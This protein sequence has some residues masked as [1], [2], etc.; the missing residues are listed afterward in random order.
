MRQPSRGDPD[1]R[2]HRWQGAGPRL[3]VISDGPFQ[4]RQLRLTGGAKTIGQSADNDLQLEDEYVSRH[5]ARVEARSDA[6]VIEDT[7]ST[8]GVLVNGRLIRRRM[9]LHPGDVVQLGSLEL[10]LEPPAPGS[11]PT[12]PAPT[13]PQAGVQYTVR[14]QRAAGDIHNVGRDLHDNRSYRFGI[15][16]MRRRARILLRIGIVLFLAGFAVYGYAVIAAV[17]RV[18]GLIGEPLDPGSPPDFGEALQPVLTYAAPGLVLNFAGLVV[19]VIGLLMRR[20]VNA[21]ERGR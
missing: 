6:V 14:D 4:G 9:P 20:S 18:F 5:H 15:T 17:L 10:R 19:I 21:R 7:G 11:A 3:V 16:P 13:P 8:N 2:T 1:E 12:P